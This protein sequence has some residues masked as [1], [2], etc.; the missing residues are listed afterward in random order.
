MNRSSTGETFL[1]VVVFMLFCTKLCK[2]FDLSIELFVFQVHRS[3]Q[4]QLSLYSS[5]NDSSIFSSQTSSSSL[6][7]F[8]TIVPIL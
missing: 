7:S 5:Q 3:L 8:F 4:V 1:F 2:F 6:F